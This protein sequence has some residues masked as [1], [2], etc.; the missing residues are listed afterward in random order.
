[1]FGRLKSAGLRDKLAGHCLPGF[2]PSA[3]SFPHAYPPPYTGVSFL[4]HILCPLI[5]FFQVLMGSEESL[6]YLAYGI[7]IGAPLVLLPAIEAYRT[8]QSLFLAF[9]VIWGLLTQV[10]TVGAVF[11]LYWLT[12]IMTGG[13]KKTRNYPSGSFKQA[14]AEAIV[15]G[16]IVGAAIPSVAMLVMDDPSIIALWQPYPAYVSV[17]QFLH[18]RFRPSSKYSHSGFRTMQVL[19]LGCLLISSSV[20]VSTIWPLLGNISQTKA[21]L[22]P[23]LS[24]LDHA[25]DMRVHILEFLKWDIL[26]AYSATA[27]ALLWF[28]R[29]AMQLVGIIVWYMIG[30]PLFG[31][32]ATVMGV[33]IWKDDLLG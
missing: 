29:S 8:G 27:L 12:V 5:T 4:D 22:I 15:F 1:M 7:G 20:H 32:G 18:L 19:Y 31:F 30:I 16:I 11:P 6:S 28:A 25:A 13:V 23:S 14:E 26:I 17:A 3:T 21:F 33:A 24:P 2:V 10:A 9:P